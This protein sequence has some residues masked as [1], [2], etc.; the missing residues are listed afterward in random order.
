[1]NNSNDRDVQDLI[2]EFV[3]S[4][5]QLLHEEIISSI[6]RES[7]ANMQEETAEINETVTPTSTKQASSENIADLKKQIEALTSR[8]LELQ[9][10]LTMA[11][12]QESQTLSSAK[13]MGTD[14]LRMEF[15]N[16]TSAH[17]QQFNTRIK[18]T[19]ELIESL[20]QKTQGPTE[21]KSNKDFPLWLFWTNIAVLGIIALYFIIQ[22]FTNEQSTEPTN[23]QTS[24][25]APKVTNE[26]KK[27]TA[28]ITQSTPQSALP[29]E[30]KSTI[31]SDA[32]NKVTTTP[33]QVSTPFRV[34]NTPAVASKP[35]ETPVNTQK[36]PI[37]ARPLTTPTPK[38]TPQPVKT[39]LTPPS[40]NP[41]MASS[42]KT[43]KPL[44]KPIVKTG[45]Q[46]PQVTRVPSTV[47]NDSRKPIVAPKTNPQPK[48]V[49][50]VNNKPEPVK[51]PVNKEKVYF[52]ED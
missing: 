3:S 25:V 44:S 40:V 45:N 36:A 7:F 1:M 43:S 30:N 4:K 41:V 52:G 24:I 37:N 17:I 28:P 21:K 38:P 32:E 47:P 46:S 42:N 15:L 29:A 49:A 51:K 19:E 39:T 22:M 16:F 50:V 6:K 48:P 5:N 10:E 33:Q 13:P 8:N 35:M 12:M 34:A 31:N 23:M 11:Q 26:P 18:K 9:Q 20:T 27:Q 14:D 2:A